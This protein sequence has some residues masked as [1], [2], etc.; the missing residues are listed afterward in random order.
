MV[1]ESF[2]DKTCLSNISTVDITSS[3]RKLLDLSLIKEQEKKKSNYCKKYQLSV[4]IVWTSY[5][6]FNLK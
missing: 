4:I 6:F 3:R 5:I 2:K 1:K